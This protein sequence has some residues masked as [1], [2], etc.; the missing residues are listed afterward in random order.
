MVRPTLTLRAGRVFEWSRGLHLQALEDTRI[1]F[2]GELVRDGEK[3]QNVIAADKDA[4]I[5]FQT[6]PDGSFEAIHLRLRAGQRVLLH[7]S[8]DVLLVA[9]DGEERHFRVLSERGA[10]AGEL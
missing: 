4:Q 1:A 10:Y 7:R 2:P 5:G 6:R 3:I 9:P 8:S